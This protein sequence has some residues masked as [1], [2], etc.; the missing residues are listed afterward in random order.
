MARKDEQHSRQFGT[1]RIDFTAGKWQGFIL[2]PTKPATGTG[3][4]KPWIWYAPTFMKDPFPLP[5]ELHA[6]YIERLLAAGFS[7]AGVDVGESWGSPAGREGYTAFYGACVKRYGLAPKACLL[8]QS[9]GGLFH[10]NWAAEHPECVQCI[11][12]IYT[13]V[14]VLGLRLSD[15]RIHTAYGMDEQT[16]RREVA[17]HNPIDR[18]AP[19]AKARVPLFNIHGDNDKIVPLE[20]NVGELT[21][22]YRAL[23]GEAELLVLP[24]QGH[25]EIPPFFTNPQLLEFFL[26]RGRPAA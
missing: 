13:L 19:L 24:G 23:G 16:V 9:R 1:D 4:A 22:R 18:L 21:R 17:K 5:K 12:G 3:H 11:G 10:Y 6:W 20:D 8:P 7:V 15:A 14:N 2:N 25:E 26:T